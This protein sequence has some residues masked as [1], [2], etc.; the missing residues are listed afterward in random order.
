MRSSYGGR[1]SDI[2]EA[3]ELLAVHRVT[4]ADLITHILPLA[5]AGKGFRLVA[6][7]KDSIKVVLR[8]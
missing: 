5:E 7:A 2:R 4:V 8:P 1:A 6:E 3:I